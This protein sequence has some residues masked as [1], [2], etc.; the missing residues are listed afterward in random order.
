MERTKAY[1]DLISADYSELTDD[2]RK[3]KL[4]CEALPESVVAALT[5]RAE[6]IRDEV[7]RL[8]KER[9]EIIDFLNG[10]CWMDFCPPFEY[11]DKD[12]DAE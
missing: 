9:D 6:K 1:Y 5:V 12:G 2:E 3:R 4:F 7:L 11:I 10:F 8:E